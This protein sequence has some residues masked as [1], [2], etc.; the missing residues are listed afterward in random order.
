MSSLFQKTSTLRNLRESVV[1][2]DRMKDDPIAADRDDLEMYERTIQVMRSTVGRFNRALSELNDV[3]VEM[4]YELRKFYRNSE[5]ID[6][7]KNL[8]SVIETIKS[9]KEFHESGQDGLTNVSSKL[10]ALLAM[11]A[12]LGNKLRERDKAYSMKTH[13]EEKMKSIKDSAAEEKVRRNTVKQQEANTEFERIESEVIRQ[14]RETLNTRFKD[15]NQIMGLYLKFLHDYYA[16]VGGKFEAIQDLPDT[17]MTSRRRNSASV[18]PVGFVDEPLVYPT[19][20]APVIPAAVAPP[21]MVTSVAE[22]AALRSALGLRLQKS[23][24]PTSS[25]NDSDLQTP[26]K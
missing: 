8:E 5:D 16:G 7:G 18:V 24:S 22:S 12:S 15:L 13:Y 3:H 21:P 25:G 19:V 9:I 26:Q 6:D 10:D 23:N 14:T 17:L 2:V 4:A 1:G 11:H 20:A